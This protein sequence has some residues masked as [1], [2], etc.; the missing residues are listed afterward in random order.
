MFS[1]ILI[2]LILVVATQVAFAETLI[3]NGSYWS[4]KFAIEG[5]KCLHEQK[6]IKTQEAMNKDF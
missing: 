2:F 4:Y 3:C 1:R 6:V 5:D